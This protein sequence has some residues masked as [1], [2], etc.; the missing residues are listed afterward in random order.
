MGGPLALFS[1]APRRC[2][3]ACSVTRVLSR[4]FCH[5]CS[6]TRVVV[7]ACPRFPTIVLLSA[8]PE[9]VPVPRLPHQHLSAGCQARNT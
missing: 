9:T 7:Q 2:G 5:A 3:D 4:V 8:A 1:H 6:V